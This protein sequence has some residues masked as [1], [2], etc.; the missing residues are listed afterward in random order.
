[1]R[2]PW[3][4]Q[5]EQSLTLLCPYPYSFSPGRT[6][7]HPYALRFCSGQAFGVREKRTPFGGFATTFPP[8]QGALWVLRIVLHGTTGKRSA[9]YS[10][11]C[12]GWQ[13]NWICRE[14]KRPENPVTCFL[15]WQ[16]NLVRREAKRPE[17]QVR[18]FPVEEVRRSRIGGS[19]RRWLIP[20]DWYLIA[21]VS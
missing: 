2:N 6:A 1:M 15:R 4:G 10:A 11:P 12:I 18:R 14:A 13:R 21:F 7:V 19:H 3:I 8:V 17:N 20:A 5:D 16:A 9:I